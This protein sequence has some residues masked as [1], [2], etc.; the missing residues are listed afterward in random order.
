MSESAGVDNMKSRYRAMAITAILIDIIVRTIYKWAGRNWETAWQT[1]GNLGR[2][3]L[4]SGSLF[5]AEF[6]VIM[7]VVALLIPRPYRVRLAGPAMLLAT[8]FAAVVFFFDLSAVLASD[9]VL[10]P[11]LH[12]LHLDQAYLYSIA[13]GI[14]WFLLMCYKIKGLGPEFK[15]LK[16]NSIS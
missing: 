6:L 15:R 1:S 9:P 12:M 11:H 8:D 5:I 10:S 13:F 3:W 16:E 7:G 4:V 2:W 14:I